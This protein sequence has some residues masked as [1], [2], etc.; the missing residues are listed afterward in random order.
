MDLLE[1]V[2]VMLVCLKHIH[3]AILRVLVVVASPYAQPEV[4]SDLLYDITLHGHPSIPSL[5]NLDQILAELYAL[6]TLIYLLALLAFAYLFGS[7]LFRNLH[8]LLLHSRLSSNAIVPPVFII[9]L[10]TVNKW[11]V[12]IKDPLFQFED[13]WVMDGTPGNDDT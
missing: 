12:Q 7:F 5:I 1:Q 13:S 3:D 2:K 9:L 11:C 8:L 6:L 4:L 10:I